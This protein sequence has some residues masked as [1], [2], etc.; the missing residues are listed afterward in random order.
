L[1]CPNK[2]SLRERSPASKVD[3]VQFARNCH[4]EMLLS[5][6]IDMAF[7]CS[8]AWLTSF[9]LSPRRATISVRIF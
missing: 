9:R 4:C 1:G 2:K 6:L 7:H 5:L 8:H 3:V